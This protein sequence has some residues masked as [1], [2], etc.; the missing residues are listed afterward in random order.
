MNPFEGAPKPLEISGLFLL[1]P[2]VLMKLVGLPASKMFAEMGMESQF[3]ALEHIK[4]GRRKPSINMLTSVL[5][6]FPSAEVEEFK[7]CLTEASLGDSGALL[8]LISSAWKMTATG[9]KHHHGVLF[10]HLAYM[11]EVEAAFLCGTRLWWIGDSRKQATNLFLEEPLLAP[12]FWPEITQIFCLS[13]SKNELDFARLAL[14]LEIALSLFAAIEVQSGKAKSNMI[15]LKLVPNNTEQK[16]PV[17]CFIFWLKERLD[18]NTLSELLNHK[19]L[20]ALEL[21][22]ST[23]KRW[24][25][26]AVIPR[27]DAIWEIKKYWRSGTGAD[28]LEAMYVGMLYMNFLGYYWHKLRS[29]T[30]EQSLL[31]YG[32]SSFESWVGQRYPFWYS[33]H[34][35]RYDAGQVESPSV[36][37][38]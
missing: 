32:Y 23:V 10:Y 37:P 16:N 20:Q 2:T 30:E 3:K 31:P 14:I 18:V 12:F 9:S 36:L 34:K 35:T 7:V 21:D 4:A 15:F 22:E 6:N 11:A 13:E 29:C 17:G 19:A 27:Q 24:N 26:G 38:S 1:S 5:G 8:K 28:E 33:F 25:S